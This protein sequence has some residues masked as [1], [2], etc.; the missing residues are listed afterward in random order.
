[1]VRKP[2][3]VVLPRWKK[4][5][6]SAAV[7][8][9]L[10]VCL[11]LLL[12]LSG[13]G[14]PVAPGATETASIEPT[15]LDPL[16]YFAVC[17]PYLGYRNRAHG[18]Y[19]TWYIKGQPLCTTDEYGYRNGF[20]WPGQGNS[21]IV[22]FLGDSITFCAEVDDQHTGPSE[23]AKLLSEELDVRVLNAGVR[24]YSTLQA[25]RTLLECLERFPRVRVAV[26]T[27]CGNDIEENTVPNLRYPLKAPVV[28]RDSQ[29]G[30]FRE[31]EVSEPAVPWG[32]DFRT[33]EG[34]AAVLGRRAEVA[35]WL[36]ARSALCYRCLAGWRQVDFRRFSPREFPDGTRVVPPADYPR[37]HAWAAENGGYEVFR[38]LLAE[39]DRAC[40]AQGVVFLVTSA[41]SGVYFDGCW[42]FSANCARS[43]TAAGVRFVSMEDEFTGS[44]PYYSSVRVD[45]RYDG[46]YGPLGTQ[47]YA[48]ALTPVLKEILRFRREVPRYGP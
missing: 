4:L 43:C 23:V 24:G 42:V 7:V 34:P 39:M 35:G 28:M 8:V 26:Y 45:G 29:S 30:E 13:Y 2:V 5:L 22:L 9:F 31:V 11:E 16:T 17:D 41:F 36:E 27:F 47:T 44:P 48:K 25:K 38:H 19:R 18:S 46:H 6:F 33:W 10:L 12:R 14:P 40:R 15:Q 1:M 20:G 21:P 3:R 32:E 37:W